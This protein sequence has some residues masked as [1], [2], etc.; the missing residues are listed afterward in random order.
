MAETPQ[1]LSIICF[2]GDFDKALAAM[3]MANGGRAFDYE[4][5]L[6]FTFWGLNILKKRKGRR[7]GKGMFMQR[8]FNMMMGGRNNLPLSKFNFGGI[9]P[10][11]MKGI[12]KKK[13]IK[14]VDGML[15]DA[16]GLGAKIYACDMAMN[17]M[18]VSK[19]DLIDE[20]TDIVGVGTFIANAE[21]GQV[22]FI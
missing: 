4:V 19:E 8:M 3:V 16:I 2:S 6:F 13:N 14:D 21:G 9:G 15:Q 11:L 1:K 22:L 18:G 17:V 20:I 5:N 10:E 7:P 12:M